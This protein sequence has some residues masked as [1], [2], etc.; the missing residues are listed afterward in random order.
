VGNACALMAHKNAVFTTTLFA[1]ATCTPIA[2]TFDGPL[3]IIVCGSCAAF[4]VHLISKHTLPDVAQKYLPHF[5]V[6][7]GLLGVYNNARSMCTGP[8]AFAPPKPA[9]IDVEEAAR[10]SYTDVF[11]EE[12]PFKYEIPEL[13]LARITVALENTGSFHKS[14]IAKLMQIVEKHIPNLHKYHAIVF[15]NKVR[16][17][18][19]CHVSGYVPRDTGFIT[20]AFDVSGLVN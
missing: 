3:S 16:P 9:T 7:V 8:L 14:D 4:M 5:I 18:A 15:H 20:L 19:V 10:F 2:R 12:C 17:Y 11:S 6:G 1:A 13:T